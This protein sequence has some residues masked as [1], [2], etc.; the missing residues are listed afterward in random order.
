MSSIVFQTA[1]KVFSGMDAWRHPVD[2]GREGRVKV[3]LVENR[4]MH[5]APF[6]VIV[7][8]KDKSLLRFCRSFTSVSYEKDKNLNLCSTQQQ[9][10]HFAGTAQFN[11][12]GKVR[13]GSMCRQ[14]CKPNR[15]K[16]SVATD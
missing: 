4:A 6:D 13:Q 7:S 9:Q 3:K 5:V 8:E 16:L 2:F 14:K 10:H 12:F 1:L 15:E 11:K